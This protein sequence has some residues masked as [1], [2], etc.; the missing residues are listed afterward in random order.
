MCSSLYLTRYTHRLLKN[1]EKALLYPVRYGGLGAT[2]HCSSIY[3]NGKRSHVVIYLTGYTESVILRL[4]S[5]RVAG[6]LLLLAVSLGIVGGALYLSTERAP[7][8][9][10]Q[11]D[12]LQAVAQAIVSTDKDGDGLFDWEEVLWKTDPSNPDTDGDG[13]SDNDE[14][15]AGRNPLVA[16]PNDALPKP[17]AAPSGSSASIGE[18]VVAGNGISNTEALAI[19]LFNNYLTLKKSGEITGNEENLAQRLSANADVASRAP[20]YTE[21]DLR[22]SATESDEALAS[23]KALL[24]GVFRKLLSIEENELATLARAI[25]TND[26]AAFTRYEK[27]VAVYH[28]AARTL[29]VSAVPRSSASAQVGLINALEGLATMLDD[30]AQVQTDPLI[31]LVALNAYPTHDAA[32]RQALKNLDSYLLVKNIALTP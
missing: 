9:S 13:T 29:R 22:F 6:I 4:L 30:L 10:V 12:Q 7:E 32:L 5:N 3:T 23:Y 19:N 24:E 26:A 20:R 8:V 11:S 28:D 18:E 15:L 17:E 27:A 14:V 2:V 16:G 31:A 21:A 1:I 25:E